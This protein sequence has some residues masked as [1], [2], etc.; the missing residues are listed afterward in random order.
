MTTPVNTSVTMSL[1][2][3]QRVSNGLHPGGVVLVACAAFGVGLV[4][5]M[6]SLDTPKPQSPPANHA[7]AMST[8]APIVDGV[9]S[10]D[11]RRV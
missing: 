4:V 11:I 9:Y 8:V 1:R 3:Y 6:S 5:G 2:D 10:V 7:P